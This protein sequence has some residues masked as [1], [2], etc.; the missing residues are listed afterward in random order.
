MRHSRKAPDV[1]D[2]LPS[3]RERGIRQTLLV[4]P[5]GDGYGVVAGR[6]RFHALQVIAAETGK[7][8]WGPM[9]DHGGR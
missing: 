9:R 3:I 7:S 6:R 1:S 4:R 8:F 2:I 5:E